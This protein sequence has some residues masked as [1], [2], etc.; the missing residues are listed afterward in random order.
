M[1]VYIAA[2]SAEIERAERMRD[3]LQANGFEVTSSWMEQIRQVGASNPHDESEDQREEWA[4][5]CIREVMASDVLWLL[6]PPAHIRTAGAWGEFLAAWMLPTVS[7]ISSGDTK[8]SIFCALGD[9]YASDEEAVQ[10]YFG[11]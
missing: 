8:Q 10:R 4:V 11:I 9:E 3:L 5:Q 6:V 1:K 2:A 7:V